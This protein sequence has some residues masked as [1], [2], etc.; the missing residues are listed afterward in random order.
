MKRLLI[1]FAVLGFAATATADLLVS[2]NFQAGSG[3]EATRDNTFTNSLMSGSQ[4]SR[5]TGIT[6][7]GNTNGFSANAYQQPDLASAIE[8]NDYFTWDVIGQAGTTF[9][10]TNVYYALIRTATGPSN[11]TLRANFDNYG[12]DLWGVSNLSSTV[13]LTYGID[14]SGTAA[15]QN[16][17][18]T[19]NFRLYGYQNAASGG[20]GRIEDEAGGVGNDDLDVFGTAIPEPGTLALIAL[21]LGALIVRRIRR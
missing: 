12:S 10:I 20:T 2:W 6:A 11:F 19:V 18:G 15:L 16:T 3:S 8:G 4:I 13:T 21:G 5:G 17:N 7:T 9:S 14:V 1:A